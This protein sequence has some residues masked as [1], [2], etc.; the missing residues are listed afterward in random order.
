MLKVKKRNLSSLKRLILATSHYDLTRIPSIMAAKLVSMRFGIQLE[1]VDEN[2]LLERN[3]KPYL[4]S[5]MLELLDNRI[6]VLR[7]G[8]LL[9]YFE[10]SQRIIEEIQRLNLSS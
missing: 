4:P 7:V 1:I 9:N 8:G 3:L 6:L 2:W 5:F 10:L